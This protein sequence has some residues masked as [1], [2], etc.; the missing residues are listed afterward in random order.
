MMIGCFA[1]RKASWLY[2][3]LAVSL[4]TTP[5]SVFRQEQRLLISLNIPK[6]ILSCKNTGKQKLSGIFYPIIF[7]KSFSDRIGIPN[8]LALRSFDPAFSPTTT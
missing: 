8:S 5:A 1:A 4:N 3:A 7:K 6:M 2:T